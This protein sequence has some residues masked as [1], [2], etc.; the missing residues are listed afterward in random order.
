MYVFL[1]ATLCLHVVTSMFWAGTTF[2]LAR[3]DG[4]AAEALFR[5]Q[6]GAAVAA[7][8][9]GAVIWHFWHRPAYGPRR[10]C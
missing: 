7:F 1:V 4:I 9:T 3:D 8:L 2:T 6:M 5:P 10:W